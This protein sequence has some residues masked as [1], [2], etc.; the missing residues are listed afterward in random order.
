MKKIYVII[1]LFTAFVLTPATNMATAAYSANQSGRTPPKGESVS[2]SPSSNT[3]RLRI[4]WGQANCSVFESKSTAAYPDYHPGYLESVNE[5]FGYTLASDYLWT[6]C[7]DGVDTQRNR[8]NFGPGG[9][10]CRF[11]GGGNSTRF[12]ADGMFA[13][14]ITINLV[15]PLTRN[16]AQFPA[17]YWAS[18]NVVTSCVED[19]EDC[20]FDTARQNAKCAELKLGPTVMAAERRDRP[21]R[22]GVLAEEGFRYENAAVRAAVSRMRIGDSRWGKA[23]AEWTIACNADRYFPLQ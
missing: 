3:Y 21:G 14:H 5:G 23:T 18:I 17:G 16:R 8:D 22:S 1:A 6:A 4:C 11:V 7:V 12:A 15:K 13:G 2:S 19:Q 9:T 10:F 20:S